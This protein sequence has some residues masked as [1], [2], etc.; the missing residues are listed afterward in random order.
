MAFRECLLSAWLSSTYFKVVNL[1]QQRS[2]AIT[3]F[4]PHFKV[5]QTEL[6]R[7]KETSLGYYSPEVPEWGMELNSSIWVPV[8]YRLSAGPEAFLK[9][10]NHTLLTQRNCPLSGAPQCL[11]YQSE[12]YV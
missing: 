6:Q 10:F 1:T 5:Q 12:P 2:E 3:I 8:K 9:T 7:D 11:F 4:I